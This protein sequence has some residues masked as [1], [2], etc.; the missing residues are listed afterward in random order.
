MVGQL[1]QVAREGGNLFEVM[2]DIVDTAQWVQVTRALFEVGGRIP[3]QRLD[4]L[5]PR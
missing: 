5:T 2:M 4:R 3:P 1:K